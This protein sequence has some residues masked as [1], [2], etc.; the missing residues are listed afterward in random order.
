M[1]EDSVVD[2]RI[3]NLAKGQPKKEVVDV[4]AKNEVNLPLPN[5]GSKEPNAEYLTDNT[6]RE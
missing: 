2:D 6:S 5:G 1:P 3:E 4:P